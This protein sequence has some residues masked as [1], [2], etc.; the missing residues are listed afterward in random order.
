MKFNPKS[1]RRNK[2]FTRGM[3]D[4]YYFLYSECAR[5]DECAFRHSPQAKASATICANWP[6]GIPC[7][8]TCPYRHTNYHQI[9]CQWEARGGCK[10]PDCP[11]R[12]SLY[13]GS[14]GGHPNSYGDGAQYADPATYNRYAQPSSYAPAPLLN[15]QAGYTPC[16]D[17]GNYGGGDAQNLSRSPFNA[18]RGY[19][20][21][22]GP[23]EP[24][25]MDIDVRDV[26]DNEL[27]TK[28]VAEL[29]REL[30][31]VDSLLGSERY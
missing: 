25:A 21:Q 10:K 2:I 15:R 23:E 20:V 3:E 16:Q 26:A 27:H 13:R 22:E 1:F 18:S 24:V 7:T 9:D 14:F 5:G 6:N 12:H 28:S 19:Y 29:E 11:Y 30:S 4:C 17:A 31:E 8:D